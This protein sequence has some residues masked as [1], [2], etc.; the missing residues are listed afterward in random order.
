[1]I[2]YEVARRI[3][4][5]ISLPVL[6]IFAGCD[7]AAKPKQQ[8]AAR[9]PA[10]V[11]VAKPEIADVVIDVTAVGSLDANESVILRSEVPGRIRE[12]PFSEGEPVTRGELLVS[13]DDSEYRAQVAE[14]RAA[15]EL[16]T[17]NN[18]RA[19]DL[20]KKKLGS[21]Q[22]YDEA[23]ARLEQ[24][25]ARL[26]LDESRLA[27]TRIMAPFDGIAGLRQVSPGDYVQAGQ[28][29]VNLEDID[30][31]KLSFRAPERYLSQL[32]EN[33]TA[34][35]RVDSFP[36][37]PFSGEVY[38]V[39][40][41]IDAATRTVALKALVPNT[42][43]KLRP[44]MFARVRLVLETHT[45]AVLVPEEAI[46]PR[47]KDKFIYRV[48]DGKADIQKVEIGKRVRGKAEI[49][50]G[51]KAGDTIIVTG[52]QKLGPGSQVNIVNQGPAA[53]PVAE[54]KDGKS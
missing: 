21:E 24:A 49:L 34:E 17:L 19:S 48:V 38:A 1:M 10:P 6:L 28:S 29:I 51:I 7:D 47:G 20:Y 50:S 12:I 39:D 2:R 43:R 13:L 14:D 40:P 53:A 3:G 8:S 41:R 23:R 22:S 36:G 27:K 32:K 54:K 9:P 37:T 26:A 35:L 30:V 15:L 42:D 25:R 44:G 52:H 5:V 18:Q 33:L 31:I 4:I 45:D 16:A 11:E 46:V